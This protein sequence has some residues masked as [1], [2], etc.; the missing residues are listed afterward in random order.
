MHNHMK[1]LAVA[2]MVLLI[3]LIVFILVAKQRT[4]S[5]EKVGYFLKDDEPTATPAT[6]PTP[7][8]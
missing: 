1:V 3:G 7:N 2:N 8:A 4:E 5:G 6:T